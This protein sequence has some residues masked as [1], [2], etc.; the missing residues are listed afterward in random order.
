[1]NST[2]PSLRNARSFVAGRRVR[3]CEVCR[4][5]R[6]FVHESLYDCMR[7]KAGKITRSKAETFCS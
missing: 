3:Q 5:T 6:R 2:N 4:R 1:M 7:R